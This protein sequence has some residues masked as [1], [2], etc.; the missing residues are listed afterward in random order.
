MSAKIADANRMAVAMLQ[1]GNHGEALVSFRRALVGIKQSVANAN[2]NTDLARRQDKGHSHADYLINAAQDPVLY[3]RGGTSNL[4]LAVP[5]GYS[6]SAEDWK[7]VASPGNLIYVY[8]NAFDF[9]VNLQ[10]EIDIVNMLSPVVLFNIALA[11]HR[12]ALYGVNSSKKLRKALQLYS[13]AS[14]LLSSEDNVTDLYIIQLAVLNNMGQFTVIFSKKTIPSNAECGFTRLY[15]KVQPVRLHKAL[16]KG[17]ARS[18]LSMA[19]CAFFIRS[20]L[21]LEV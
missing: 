19:S 18:L 2:N 6:A 21:R 15:L 1:D 13:M 3:Q 14:T 10:Q 8:N 9:G 7:S 17:P 16:F 5:P 11:Y 4:L 20:A 12:K